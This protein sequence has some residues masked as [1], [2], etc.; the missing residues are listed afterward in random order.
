MTL[1]VLVAA[2]VAVGASA[3]LVLA[4]GAAN[5]PALDG[6]RTPFQYKAYAM[7]DGSVAPG[8]VHVDPATG[9]PYGPSDQPPL[10]SGAAQDGADASGV[11]APSGAA[12]IRGWL[13][14][15]FNG[16]GAPGASACASDT[17]ACSV[18]QQMQ[19]LAQ[20]L[21]SILAA[22]GTPMAVTPSDCGGTI[23]AG[24][25]A[26]NAAATDASRKTMLIEN[27]TNATEQLYVA[28]AGA[29]TVGGAGNFAD[30][31][32]GGSTNMTFNGTVIQTAVSVNAT[33]TAHRFLCTYTH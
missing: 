5:I 28:V 8:S 17:T 26:Q 7:P 15:L 23:T 3:L 9:A 6:T 1:R 29:A 13:S 22:I 2:I 20:R 14:S 25:T 10:P 21:T 31:S 16:I 4:A 11:T 18:N 30:L 33:T 19:R 27:P 32:P 12:G 24:G